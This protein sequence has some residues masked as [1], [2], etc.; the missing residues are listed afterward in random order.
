MKV[1]MNIEKGSGRGLTEVA[2]VWRDGG[3]S[4]QT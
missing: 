2:I 1:L 3:K 4:G